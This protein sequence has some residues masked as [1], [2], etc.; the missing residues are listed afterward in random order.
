MPFPVWGV[1]DTVAHSPHPFTYTARSRKTQI[2]LSLL[3][4]TSDLAAVLH[5][6]EGPSLP[7]PLAWTPVVRG[8]PVSLIICLGLIYFPPFSPNS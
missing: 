5:S 8:N 4:A 7:V 1:T 6:Q 2:Y 3:L